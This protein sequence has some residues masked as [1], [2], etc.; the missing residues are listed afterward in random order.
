MYI[1]HVKEGFSDRYVSSNGYIFDHRNNYM[2]SNP[3][4][5]M[6]IQQVLHIVYNTVCTKRYACESDVLSLCN[7]LC[8][9]VANNR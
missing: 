5:K 6:I 4:D 7:S 3:V 1:S 8:N 2:K 9:H